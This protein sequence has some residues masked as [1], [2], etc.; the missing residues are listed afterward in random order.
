MKEEIYKDAHR[1]FSIT[2]V[3]AIIEALKEKKQV[4]LLMNRR[5]FYTSIQCKNCGDV[6]KCPNCDISLTYHKSNK[7]L[8]T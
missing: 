5:G 2:L 1:I 6:I 3:N 4:L 7:K 8:F